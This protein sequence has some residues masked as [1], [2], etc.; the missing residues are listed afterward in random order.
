MIA[1][2]MKTLFQTFDQRFVYNGL[3]PV[4]RNQSLNNTVKIQKSIDGKV[5]FPRPYV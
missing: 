5:D 2:K 3:L 4:T 1:T